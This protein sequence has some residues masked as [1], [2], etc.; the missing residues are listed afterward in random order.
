MLLFF[1]VTHLR[2]T[3]SDPIRLLSEV[4]TT[5]S[6]SAFVR[7]ENLESILNPGK[8]QFAPLTCN[9]ASLTLTR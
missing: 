2:Q 5:C 9:R 8:A 7:E 4:A 1:Y 6:G 3:K